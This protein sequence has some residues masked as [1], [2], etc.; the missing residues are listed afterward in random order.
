MVTVACT[1]LAVDVISL[2]K[3]LPVLI[4]LELHFGLEFHYFCY[5]FASLA[6]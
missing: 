5:V 4:Q 1:G 2:G 6:N 3:S